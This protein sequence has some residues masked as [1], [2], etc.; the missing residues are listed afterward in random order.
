VS[1]WISLT[2][3]L[4]EKDL[5]LQSEILIRLATQE[6]IDLLASLDENKADTSYH[7]VRQ[8]IKFWNDYGLRCVYV[9]YLK[10]DPIPFCWQYVI[11]ASDIHLLKKIKYSAMYPPLAQ[12]AVH[13]EGGYVL[14]KQ[15]QKSLFTK[16]TR[17]LIK[18]LYHKGIRLF[19]CHVP[20]DETKVP[21]L[22]FLAKIGYAPDHWISMVTTRL[23][24]FR[25]GVF[26]HHRIKA[27]DYGTFPLTLFESNE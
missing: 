14:Y 17:S 24:F 25:S 27:S 13:L 7:M 18:F 20:C 6:D 22:N 11:F 21:M 9:G 8:N 3:Q 15:R 16:F 19:R 26:V 1:R 5:E 23:P 2:Y 4:S 10:D 12:D